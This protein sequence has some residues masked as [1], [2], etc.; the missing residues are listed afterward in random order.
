MDKIS[1]EGIAQPL[2]LITKTPRRYA[3]GDGV[4]AE[5]IAT[6]Q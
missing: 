5:L 4:C 3:D 2:M 1:V 6:D